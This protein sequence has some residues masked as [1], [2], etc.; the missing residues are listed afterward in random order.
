MDTRNTQK[1]IPWVDRE[2][3]EAQASYRNFEKNFITYEQYD[4]SP[5]VHEIESSPKH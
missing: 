2:D 3:K 5:I 4:T 1:I